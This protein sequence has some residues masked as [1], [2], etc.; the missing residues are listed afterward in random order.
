MR[1]RDSSDARVTEAN[2]AFRLGERRVPPLGAHVWLDLR[3]EN[4]AWGGTVDGWL[5]RGRHVVAI[6]LLVAGKRALVDLVPGIAVHV[7]SLPPDAPPL[8]EWPEW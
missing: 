2:A 5:V 8:W 7:S 3:R 4:V 6:A 1:Y